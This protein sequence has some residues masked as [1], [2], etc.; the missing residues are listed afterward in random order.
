MHDKKVVGFEIKVLSNL[1]KRAIN[2]QITKNY[3]QELTGMQGMIIGY[4][5]H[6]SK[7]RDIYQRDI[8]TNFNIRRSSVT[9]ILQ[10]MEKNE[11]LV[12]ESVSHDAR[13]KRLVLTDKAEKINKIIHQSITE[14]ED[15]LQQDLTEIELA[16]FFHTIEKIKKNISTENKGGKQDD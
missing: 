1:L 3:G 4:I 16:Q 15:R 8:E 12:R 5:S 9:G 6:H 7:E 10:T 2:K 11:L 13:L 14:V